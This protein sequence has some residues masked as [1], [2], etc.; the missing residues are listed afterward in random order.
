MISSFYSYDYV[1][2]R[3]QGR[4]PPAEVILFAIASSREG[5]RWP[6]PLRPPEKPCGLASQ[7]M[8]PGT[9]IP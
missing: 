2:D 5:P 3:A 1:Q 4:S 9:A 8:K 6:W 7:V